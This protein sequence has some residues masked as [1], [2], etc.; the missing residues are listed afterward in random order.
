MSDTT[1]LIKEKIDI[2]QFVGQY[3]RLN[4]AGKNFKGLCPFH[5][6]KTPSFMVSPDRQS[7]HCFGCSEGGDAIKFL[8]KYENLEFYDALKILAEKAGVDIKTSGNRDFQSHNGLYQVIEAAKLF[9]QKELTA[10][11]T[12]QQYLTERGLR[13]ETIQEFEIGLAP[14][15][16]DA[17]MKAMLKL[18]YPVAQLEKAG[19]VLKTERGMYLDRFRG[20]VMFPLYNHFGKVVAFT[21]RVLPDQE[22]LNFGKY[23]N[24]PETPIFQKSKLVYGLHKTKNGIREASTAVLVEG[25]MDFLMMWQDGVPNV[26]AT[27][28]TALTLDHLAV[29]RRIAD[30]LVIA[31]DSDEAGIAASERAIDLASTVDFH[32]KVL[33]LDGAKDPADVAKAQPG[34]LKS[35]VEAALPAMQYYFYKYLNAL[36]GG[37]VEKKKG[38]RIVL[39]KIRLLESA[40]ERSHWLKELAGI[41]NIE[42][43]ALLEEMDR[44]PTV[45]SRVSLP[46]EE[47][48][49][50]SPLS[51]QELLSQRI[52][53]IIL[54]YPD[55]REAAQS[56]ITYLSLVCQEMYTHVVGESSAAKADFEEAFALASLRAS[57]EFID[58]DAEKLRADFQ[59][60]LRQLKREYFREKRQ[61]LGVEIRLAQ[62]QGDEVGMAAALKEFDVVSKELHN[63]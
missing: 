49:T 11:S 25:Q 31:F 44:V 13:P 3:V 41:T 29:L 21:G 60:L 22:N 24:S 58:L 37:I 36:K 63:I 9:F 28:G 16:P 39:Q 12:V 27:S 55:F 10:S 8:M 32:T 34:R 43:S 35:L 26:V 14:S 6:E 17:L 38:I 45:G 20:R 33:L 52:I 40:V 53:G 56:H 42:E 47:S 57:Y 23:V 54:N 4:A 59:E 19:L 62:A 48:A 18:G 30:S 7:W 61:K 51:R 1:Q 5:K 46:R 15:A 2:V 50:S